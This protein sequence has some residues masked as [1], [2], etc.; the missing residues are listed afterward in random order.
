MHV[1]HPDALLMQIF[2]EI[3]RHAFGQ[4]GDEGPVSGLGGFYDFVEYIVDLIFGGAHFNRWID[5]A[6]RA[7]H[8]FCKDTVGSFHFPTTGSG[9]EAN[10]LWTHH[11]P[12]LKAQ[13]TIVHTARQTEAI[14][15]QGCFTTEISAI[16]AANLGNG[17]MAFVNEN[18]S[19]IRNIL[20]Q[21]WRWFTGFAASQIA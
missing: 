18:Q 4:G 3:F 8:L 6:G 14:F 9:G 13:G 7:D 19:V 17:H 15:G 11:V 10:C 16:H 5:Q 12:F 20:K 1:A 21:G 2:G